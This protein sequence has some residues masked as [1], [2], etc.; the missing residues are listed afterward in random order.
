MQNLESPNVITQKVS[1]L[2][3]SFFL[4][5]EEINCTH[6]SLSL[7][8]PSHYF[9]E[10]AKL[11]PAETVHINEE[12]HLEYITLQ[13]DHAPIKNIVTFIKSKQ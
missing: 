2:L 1:A 5:L 9:D 8:M 10:V 6:V 11:Q 3:Q 4:Q 12:N 7:H 13:L